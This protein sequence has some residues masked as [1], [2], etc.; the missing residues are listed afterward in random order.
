MSES[1]R[2]FVLVCAYPGKAAA[3]ADQKLVKGLH[4]SDMVGRFETT[5]ITKDEDGR[6]HV[7]KGESNV[8]GWAAGGFVVGAVIGVM[9][10][11]SVLLTAGA[12]ALLGGFGAKDNGL[13]LKAI[14]AA[15]LDALGQLIHPGEA[16]LVVVGEESAHRAIELARLTSTRQSVRTGGGTYAEL[17]QDVLNALNEHRTDPSST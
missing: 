9:F 4:S 8:R 10:P 17:E 6:V 3:E 13:V 1:A 16:A 5:V 11:P 2:V 12:G 14:P 15:D 7:A